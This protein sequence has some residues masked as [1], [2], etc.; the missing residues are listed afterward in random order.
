MSEDIPILADISL[1]DQNVEEWYYALN[2]E[3]HGPISRLELLNLY[4]SEKIFLGTKV[5]KSGMSEWA[6]VSHTDLIDISIEPPPLK[7]E[8]VN[9]TLVWVLAFTPIIGTL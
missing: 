9:N 3:R 7:G 5:W 2:G 6:D 4:Q 8:D 1:S